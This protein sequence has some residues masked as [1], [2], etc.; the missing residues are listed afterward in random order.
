MSINGVLPDGD[1]QKWKREVAKVIQEL[2]D[3]IQRLKDGQKG[4]N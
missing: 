1:D 3:Q 4:T 2:R